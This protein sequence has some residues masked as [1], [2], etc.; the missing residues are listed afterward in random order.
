[1]I[2]IIV[3]IVHDIVTVCVLLVHII[4]IGDSTDFMVLTSEVRF[5]SSQT[6]EVQVR[7]LM[8]GIAQEFNESI[9][10]ELEPLPTMNVPIGEA[11]FFLNTIDMTIIDGDSEFEYINNDIAQF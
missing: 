8:D 2:I 11:V 6:Q 3:L 9:T 7:F 10:L 4:I 1:M 5:D